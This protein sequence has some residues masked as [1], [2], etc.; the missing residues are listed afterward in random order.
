MN[1]FLTLTSILIIVF[2]LV[3]AQLYAAANTYYVT[4][5]GNGARSGKS[6][7]NAWSVSN[8]NNS[9]NWSSTDNSNKIDPGDTVY[10]SGTITTSIILPAAVSGKA[11]SYITLDGWQ[12]GTCNPVANHDATTFGSDNGVD[13]NACPSAA[14]VDLDSESSGGIYL[15]WNSYI[16]VQD[17]QIRDVNYGIRLRGDSGDPSHVIVRRN[18]VHDTY[19]DLFVMTEGYGYHYVTVGGANGDGNF[20]YNGGEMNRSGGEASKHVNLSGDDLIFSY[21]EVSADYVANYSCNSVELHEGNNQLL[22]YN[23]VS[24]AS[25]DAA[26]SIKAPGGY[27]RIIRFNKLHHAR[28]GISVSTDQGVGNYNFYVYGNYMY[29]IGDQLGKNGLGQALRCYRFYDNIHFWA[30]VI[31]V[32]DSRGI[33]VMGQPG[34]D[35]GDVYVY[36]NTVY[37]SGQNKNLDD[38]DRNGVYFYYINGLNLRFANNIIMDSDSQDYRAIYNIVPDSQI[39][40]FNSNLYYYTGQTPQVYWNGDNGILMSKL[41]ANTWEDKGIVDNPRFTDPDGPDN[42]DGTDDD[43]FT[44]QLSSPAIDSGENLSQCFDVTVQ[45]KNYHMCY[46]DALDPNGTNW[47]RTPPIVR[48]T[49]QG[50]HGNWDRGAYIYNTGTESPTIESPSGLKIIKQ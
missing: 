26:M 23:D 44:L 12:G 8:F 15:Q 27:N 22:E 42:I 20:F 14:I 7:G 36:N 6:L 33:A 35:Q 43:N 13:L 47:K 32:S 37:K 11:G 31:S 24:Y 1:I 50:D 30:N 21:N 4:Q 10:F 40:I 49:K 28:Y 16:I 34:S 5:N 46:D 19:R 45:G 25:P 38:A 39:S 17:F 2:S 41:N 3:P 9:A 48:T 18:Y 29:N